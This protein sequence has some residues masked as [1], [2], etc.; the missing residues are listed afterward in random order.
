MADKRKAPRTKMVL[1]VKFSAARETLFAHTLDITPSGARIGALRTQLQPG[2]IVSLQRGQKKAKFRIVW[3]RQ[4]ATNEMQAGVESVDPTDNFWGVSLS[5]ET[6]ES[7]EDL[8]AFLSLLSDS[9]NAQ[10]QQP[11]ATRPGRKSANAVAG[12]IR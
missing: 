8:Q 10:L 4:L 3:V 2:T 6:P 1:P 12:K 11:P 5:D 9:S 7:K